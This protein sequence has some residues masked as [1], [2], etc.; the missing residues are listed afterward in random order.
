MATTL[1]SSSWRRQT[2]LI[3]RDPTLI[4]VGLQAALKSFPSEEVMFGLTQIF[5]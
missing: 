2:L 3:S 1:H 5:S 4:P